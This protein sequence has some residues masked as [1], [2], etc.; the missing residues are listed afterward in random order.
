[1]KKF[2]MLLASSAFITQAHAMQDDLGSDK[3]H[4]SQ[5]SAIQERELEAYKAQNP[6][7]IF[8][9]QNKSSE[10]ILVKAT[11]VGK[12]SESDTYGPCGRFFTI[13]VS[14]GKIGSYDRASLGSEWQGGEA[15]G[16][17]F[18]NIERVSIMHG[19]R[20]RTRSVPERKAFDFGGALIVT[21]EMLEKAQ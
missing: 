6:N 10:E 9:V 17:S 5:N 7:S 16:L 21:D 8:T 3:H 19:D 11:L 13:E 15:T 20:F 2:F 12:D 4:P 14:P 1:M 18:E